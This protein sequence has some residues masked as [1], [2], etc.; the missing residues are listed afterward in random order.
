M[1]L[2]GTATTEACSC[3]AACL[4]HRMDQQTIYLPAWF[5]WFQW[6]QSSNDSCLL[7]RFN[8]SVHIPKAAGTTITE[9]FKARMRPFCNEVNMDD[10]SS[11]L[12]SSGVRVWLW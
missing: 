10:P 11:V 7:V 6:F 3:M 12:V 1:P 8:L 5:H 9:W 2:A 4:I